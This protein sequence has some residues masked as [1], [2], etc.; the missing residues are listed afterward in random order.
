MTTASI[1]E[2]ML[3]ILEQ[4][5]VP[6]VLLPP[7]YRVEVMVKFIFRIYSP[8][9]QPLEH[10]PDLHTKASHSGTLG[11][12]V[13]DQVDLHM[14][15]RAISR[16]KQLHSATGP[17]ALFY[18]GPLTNWITTYASLTGNIPLVILPQ[19]VTEAE[20]ISTGHILGWDS[21]N[22]LTAPRV[23]YIFRAGDAELAEMVDM[24]LV[25]WTKLKAQL[26]NI[27]PLPQLKP[28][29]RPDIELGNHIEYVDLREPHIDD[30]AYSQELP[31]KSDNQPESVR[32]TSTSLESDKGHE[33][34]ALS[35]P[36]SSAIREVHETETEDKTGA[37]DDLDDQLYYASRNG[38][39][40]L[41]R[42]LIQKGAGVNNWIRPPLEVASMQGY[43]GIV[44]ILLE[45][46]AN[47]N[48]KS[49]P[50]D[51]NALEAAATYD[52]EVTVRKLLEAGADVNLKGGKNNNALHAGIVGGHAKI[53]RVLLDAGADISSTDRRGQTAL[54]S[55]CEQGFF[56][57]VSTL[58]SC[59][60][61]INAEGGAAL[62]MACVRTHSEIVRLLIEKGAD[63]NAIGG[64]FGNPLVAAASGGQESI[65][66]LLLGLG[67]DVN[68]YGDHGSALH[69]A[70]TKGKLPVV[71]LLLENGADVKVIGGSYG[72]PLIAA[73]SSGR[74][75]IVKLLLQNGAEINARGDRGTA[76][77]L[78]L[79]MGY[80]RLAEVLIEAGAERVPESPDQALAEKENDEERA[81]GE[82]A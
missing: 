10:A 14:F 46:G 50:L 70:S 38:N 51:S 6:V 4:I 11:T 16:L 58:I 77:Q 15:T 52:Q 73:V 54:V 57:I 64:P 2:L 42:E 48:L 82:Q 75:A 32:D 26:V 23:L 67:L 37:K 20:D 68:V 55:A 31:A 47:P 27:E 13:L 9:S 3:L 12:Q 39:E 40:E 1:A 43:N 34:G 19:S 35:L 78:A 76:L 28:R 7:R 29:V 49:G 56:N 17:S 45:A 72:T 33:K 63:V 24:P 44:K 81:R 18:Q 66:L 25:D 53:V 80:N 8:Y 65:I 69:E 71:K 59:G 30:E 21:I 74:E 5:N 79:T 61:D 36:L 60:A 41:V 22:R 62:Q